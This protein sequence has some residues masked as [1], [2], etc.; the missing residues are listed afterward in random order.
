MKGVLLKKK[1]KKKKT[2][3]NFLKITMLSQKLGLMKKKNEHY[4]TQLILLDICILDK[5]QCHIIFLY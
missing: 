2:E 5:I 1:H 4:D 3:T